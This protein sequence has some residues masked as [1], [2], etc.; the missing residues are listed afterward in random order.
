MADSIILFLTHLADQFH[1]P[2]EAVTLVWTVIKILVIAVPLLIIMAYLTYAERKVLGA[3]QLRQ[4]P[5]MV[6][7]YGL[8][9]AFADGIKLFGK[10]TIIPS[11]A[12]KTLFII[13]PMITFGMSLV[14]WA[15]IPVGSGLVRKSLLAR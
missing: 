13:A 15:V 8:L 11:G 10:E 1:L 14:A 3:M 7:P 12:D 4:G 9:Q 5:M 6:G 2:H